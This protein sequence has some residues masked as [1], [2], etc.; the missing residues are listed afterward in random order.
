MKPYTLLLIAPMLATCSVEPKQ[1]TQDLEIPTH[2]KNPSM[3]EVEEAIRTMDLGA[4]EGAPFALNDK[5]LADYFQSNPLVGMI[6]F[7]AYAADSAHG[8]G[9]L[10]EINLGDTLTYRH[11]S[12]TINHKQYYLVEGDM[13]LSKSRY[14]QYKNWLL[15]RPKTDSTSI[16]KLIGIEKDGVYLRQPPGVVIRYAVIHDSFDTEAKYAQVV[17]CMEL[18]TQDWEAACGVRFEHVANMDA[19]VLFEPTDDLTFIVTATNVHGAF[20]ACSF[21]PD[22][23]RNER[24]LLVDQSYFTTRYHRV[25]IF[26]HEI[27]HILGWLHEAARPEAPLACQVE[28]LEGALNLTH[29]D[30]Q[31]V[32]HYFCEGVGSLELM[33]SDSDRFGAQQVYGPPIVM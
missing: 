27:G 2:K 24:A 8:G 17:Q 22:Q 21:F 16:S 19:Q 11:R 29:Y 7:R 26:R 15:H 18:A 3:R 1:Q 25:G 10:N 14:I 6:D 32:M 30:P 13:L 31:S 23:P 9:E 4:V 33:L 28:V 12:I 20:V 5:F